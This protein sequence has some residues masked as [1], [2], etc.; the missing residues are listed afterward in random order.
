MVYFFINFS[1][2]NFHSD[3]TCFQRIDLIFVLDSSSA[4]IDEQFR[5]MTDFIAM[6]VTRFN[7]SDTHTV[8]G[9]VQYGSSAIVTVPIRS[10]LTVTTL[11]TAVRALNSTTTTGTPNI[12]NAI[13]V[14]RAHFPRVDVLDLDVKKIMVIFVNRLEEGPSNTPQI[15]N[16][17]HNAVNEGIE[18]YAIGTANRETLNAIASDPDDRHVFM[19]NALDTTVLFGILDTFS[20]RACTSELSMCV[21]VSFRGRGLGVCPFDLF[22]PLH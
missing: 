8:V 22:S 2:S 12:T 21:R 5:A 3:A 17:A 1:L 15:M 20:I 13:N 11:M 18:V 6:A 9:V 7:I 14:A 10:A 16:A 19:T 4:V